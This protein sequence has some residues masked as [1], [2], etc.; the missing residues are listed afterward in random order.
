MSAASF[1]TGSNLEKWW[2]VIP[3]MAGALLLFLSLRPRPVH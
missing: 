3:I 1:V 2:P